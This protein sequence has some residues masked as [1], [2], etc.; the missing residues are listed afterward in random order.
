MSEKSTINTSMNFREWGLLLALSILWG[1]SFFFNGVAVREL[2]TFTIVVGRVALASLTLLLVMSVAGQQ[3]PRNRRDWFA[4]GGMG[5]LNNVVPFCLIVWEQDLVASG[6][7]SILNATTPLFTVVVA[8]FMT[9]DE[10]MMGGRLI[11]VVIG[12]LG[13]VIMIGTDVLAVMNTN[14]LAHLAILG[15]SVSYAFA[16]IYGR[17][18]KAMGISPLATATGQVTASSIFLIP[19]VI[20]IDQPWTLPMPSLAALSSLFGIAVLSTAL[21]YIL[22]FRILATAGAVNLLLV[23]FLILISAILL[24]VTFLDESLLPKHLFGIALIGTGMSVVD[25]RPWK[26]LKALWTL[27]ES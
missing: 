3:M 6:V 10:K 12:F 14:L 25:S 1:C 9:S 15:A 16:G 5:F 8:H 20:L 13:F 21:A 19:M 7:A 11:G 18:F 26:K 24:G 22:Y 4:F 17:R 27:N 2:P 23:T